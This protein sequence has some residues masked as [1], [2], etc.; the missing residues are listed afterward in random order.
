MQL[1]SDTALVGQTVHIPLTLSSQDPVQGL[2][3]AFDWDG[4][5]GS[6]VSLLMGS[7]FSTTPDVWVTRVESDYMV[8]GMIVDTDSSGPTTIGPGSNLHIATAVISGIAPGTSPVV[9][10]DGVY[11]SIQSGP[12][13][14]NIIV[15]GGLSIGQAEQLELINGSF[16][17]HDEAIP[18]PGAFLLGSIGL[19]C[20]SWLRRR[21]TL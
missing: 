17:I 3:A 16:Q 1:G 5:I 8:L 12:V 2:V 19:G 9:F 4:T 20:I 14:D 10:V 11:S 6:G 21:R 13:L 15:V 18:A 7:A